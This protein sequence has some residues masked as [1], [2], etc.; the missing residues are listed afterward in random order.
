MRHANKRQEL[1]VMLEQVK[2]VHGHM[3]TAASERRNKV[4]R[5]IANEDEAVHGAGFVLSG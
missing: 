5:G 4:F 3:D 2:T 1:L